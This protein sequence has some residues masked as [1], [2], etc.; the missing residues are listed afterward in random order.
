MVDVDGEPLRPGELHRQHLRAGDGVFDLG[1]DLP[2]QLLLL[3]VGGC[4]SVPVIKNGPA[5]PFR[6]LLEMWSR[7]CSKARDQAVYEL[8]IRAPA[9]IQSSTIVTGPSLTTSTAMRAPKTLRWTWAPSLASELGVRIRVSVDTSS[10]SDSS[11][12]RRRL[13]REH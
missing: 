8:E 1:R 9:P 7:Q 12:L 6:K 3:V 10:D 2:R 11:S 4:Q 13:G 5:G